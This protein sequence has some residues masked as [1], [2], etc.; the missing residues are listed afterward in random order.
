MRNHTN[1]NDSGHN[2]GMMW[3]MIPCILLFVVLFLGGERL[4]SGGYVW[5]IL[6]GVFVVAHIWMMFTGH[7]GHGGH[8]DNNA[9]AKD[10]IDKTSV[11]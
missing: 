7:G 6:I 2:K 1:G 8:D 10:T 4:S 3:M 11:K 5:P 9:H